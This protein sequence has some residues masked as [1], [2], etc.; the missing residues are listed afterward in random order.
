MQCIGLD[1]KMDDIIEIIP[2]EDGFTKN[3]EK[4]E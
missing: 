1:C 2:D 3:T 4:G